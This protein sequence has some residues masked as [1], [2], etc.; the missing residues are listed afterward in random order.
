MSNPKK[1]E[2]GF[3]VLLKDNDPRHWVA[4]I[5]GPS[6]TPYEGGRHARRVAKINPTPAGQE[7]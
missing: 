3:T 5:K 1:N 7:A 4:E 2:E 6:D